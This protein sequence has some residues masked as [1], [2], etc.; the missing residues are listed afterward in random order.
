MRTTYRI[1]NIEIGI[2]PTG[3]HDFGF[4]FGRKTGF[5]SL[6]LCH[7]CGRRN[8]VPYV[9]SGQCCWC[10]ASGPPASAGD[11]RESDGR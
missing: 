11:E 8:D 3:D 7:E 1:G 6:I 10:G 5:E 2:D 9:S 4:S